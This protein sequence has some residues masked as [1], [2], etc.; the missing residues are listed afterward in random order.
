MKWGAAKNPAR[1]GRSGRAGRFLLLGLLLT[2]SAACGI[3]RQVPS[4]LPH[5]K[6]ISATLGNPRFKQVLATGHRGAPRHAPENTLPSFEKALEL[7]ADIIEIDVRYTRDG[8]FV[9][10]HDDTVTRLTGQ[11]GSIEQ[12]T[13]AEVQQLD[14]RM[15]EFPGLPKLKIPTLERAVNFLRNHAIIYLDHKTGPVRRLAQ[16]V[17][18]LKVVDNAYIV[19][20]TPQAA[21]EARAVSPNLHLMAAITD[22]EPA[23]LIDLFLPARPTLFELPPSYLTSENVARLRAMGIRIFANAMQTENITPYLTYQ[24]LLHSGADVIQTDYLDR[25]VPYLRPVN[26]TR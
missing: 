21:R 25:L 4:G 11:A 3:A 22:K 7:G 6:T 17:V 8:H 1:R 23:G 15:A 10:F 2:G 16:G 13:L 5:P 14:I 26:A 18:R 20:R 9:I 12:R 19:V 24:H